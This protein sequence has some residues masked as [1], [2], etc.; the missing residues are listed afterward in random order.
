MANDIFNN[1]LNNIYLFLTSGESLIDKNVSI[2]KELV[3]K[4][5]YSCIYVTVNKPYFR[6]KK[7]YETEKINMKNMIFIDLISKKAKLDIKK[8]KDCLF[9]HSP[10]SLTELSVAISTGIK[11]IKSEKKMVFFDNLSMMM[12]YNDIEVLMKFLHITISRV[13]SKNDKMILMLLKDDFNKIDELGMLVDEVIK[14]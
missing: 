11:N 10:S 9:I 7:L 5:N 1:E 4:K 8:I 14:K 6:L 13:N 2:L 12:V 3:N